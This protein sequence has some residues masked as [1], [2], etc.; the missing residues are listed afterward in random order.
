MAIISYKLSEDNLTSF[1]TEFNTYYADQMVASIDTTDGAMIKI[2]DTNINPLMDINFGGETNKVGLYLYRNGSMVYS[3]AKQNKIYRYPTILMASK[4]FI[5]HQLADVLN[6]SSH[7][8]YS[9]FCAINDD[10][11]FVT[12]TSIPG[13][14]S[15]S[16]KSITEFVTVESLNPLNTTETISFNPNKTVTPTI[17]CNVW[18]ESGIA[19]PSIADNCYLYVCSPYVSN[20]GIVTLKNVDYV[21]NGY[22]CI[23]DQEMKK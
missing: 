20:A 14:S 13:S 22:W 8:W 15:T 4:G 23:K 2:S 18:T 3:E 17:L 21:T 9:G 11:S 12:A 19:S 5:I 7:Y 6:S 1:I 10:G 16:A